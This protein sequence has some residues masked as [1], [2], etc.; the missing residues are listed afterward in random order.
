MAVHPTMATGHFAVVSGAAHSLALVSVLLLFLGAGGLARCLDD[1]R[2]WAF[3]GLVTF[4]FACV[5]VMF[6]AAVSG[7]AIPGIVRLM[8]RDVPEA[9]AMWRIA[10]AAVFQLNQ[11]FSR[12]YSEGTAAAIVLWSVVCLRTGRLSKGFAVFGCVVS[13][14]VAVLIAVGHLRLNVHGMAAVIMSEVV[15][16]VGMGVAMMR[17]EADGVAGERE[18]REA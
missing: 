11:A 7:F 8:E 2:R 14:V 15:W 6:A 17:L 16:F 3:A 13:P 12:I 1:P 5:A 18:L 9:G 4:G 10:I